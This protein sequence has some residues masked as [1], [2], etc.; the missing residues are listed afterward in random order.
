M[1]GPGETKLPPNFSAWRRIVVKLSGEALMGAR[2]HGIDQD[3]LAR[4]AAD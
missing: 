1:T 3:T 4:I 2:S